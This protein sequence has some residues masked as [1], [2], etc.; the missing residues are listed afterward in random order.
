MENW[1]F[2]EFA[3]F[4]RGLEEGDLIDKANLEEFLE[5]GNQT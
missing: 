2:K 3:G 1:N 5:S 4:A